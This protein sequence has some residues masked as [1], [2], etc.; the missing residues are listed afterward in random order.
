MPIFSDTPPADPRGPSYQIVRT[1]TGQPLV[2]IVTSEN[3]VGCFTH[4]WKRR[5]MPCERE[6]C[7]AC[8]SG[9]PF[10]WHAYISAILSK[11][12]A[13]VLFECTAQAAESFVTYREAHGTTRGCLFTASRMNY[14]PNARIII[15]C[16][17]ADLREIILPK[18]PN[19][20]KCLAI[21]WDFPISEV[22]DNGTP[23]KRGQRTV[24]RRPIPDKNP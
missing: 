16:K 24:T 1:P 13:H 15:N 3:L 4:F 10:R 5:T 11:T 7:E 6:N 18:P 23:A 2:G 21:L 14:A 9:I 8:Q 22:D 19:I 12:R 20:V 17:P